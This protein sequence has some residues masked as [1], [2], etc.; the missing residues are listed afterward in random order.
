M[1]SRFNDQAMDL[2]SLSSALIP[3]DN[4][5]NFDIDNICT[6]I[7]K[8]YPKDFTEQEKVNLPFQLRHFILD[9]RQQPELKNL[10]T[11]PKLSRCLVETK[12]SEVYYLINRLIHLIDSSNFYSYDKT[13]IFSNKNNEDKIEE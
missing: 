9:A 11:I 7:D 13:I 6:L 12:K 3:K 2:L 8:Y 1:N 10:S 5:K 4:Y